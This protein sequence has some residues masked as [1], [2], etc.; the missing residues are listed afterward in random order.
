MKDVFAVTK[1]FFPLSN[2]NLYVRHMTEFVYVNSVT[3]S[4]VFNNNV[5]VMAFFPQYILMLI[6]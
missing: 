4:K 5:T 2:S 3:V 1:L 6:I